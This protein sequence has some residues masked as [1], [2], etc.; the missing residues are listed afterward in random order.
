MTSYAWDATPAFPEA[1]RLNGQTDVLVKRN[2]LSQ[3]DDGETGLHF[4][5]VFHLQRY[6]GDA[7]AVEG[8]QTVELSTDQV[9]KVI[10]IKARSIMPDGKVHELKESDFR[11]RTDDR[12][13]ASELYFAFEGLQVGSMVEYIIFTE[14][15]ANYNG[16]VARL[17]FSIPA[18]EQRYGSDRAGELA[19]RFQK[20]QRCPHACDRQQSLPA[21]SGT[22]WR[23]P[24]WPRSKTSGAPTPMCTAHTSYTSWMPCRTGTSLTSA[25]TPLP[26]AAIT[27]P[28]TPSS[29]PRPQRSSMHA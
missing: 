5:K 12:G 17:Q 13:S 4:Y 6:L 20:P 24:I 7:A 2:M 16:T 29:H 21:C 15:T 23:C 10:S 28:C 8:S 11:Q 25:A 26:H 14:E 19:L 3:F 22:T 27:R 1:A 18:L 9:I